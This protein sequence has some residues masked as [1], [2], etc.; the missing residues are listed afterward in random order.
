MCDISFLNRNNKYTFPIISC[1]VCEYTRHCI[2]DNFYLSIFQIKKNGK[3]VKMALFGNGRCF[4]RVFYR[5]DWWNTFKVKIKDTNKMD[6][7]YIYYIKNSATI[8]LASI[9]I[10]VAIIPLRGVGLGIGS[11]FFSSIVGLIG[12]F[13]FTNFIC[14]LYVQEIPPKYILLSILFGLTVSQVTIMILC[15]YIIGIFSDLIINLFGIIGGYVYYKKGGTIKKAIIYI[16]LV[17]C[18]GIVGVFV[19]SNIYNFNTILGIINP[20]TISN[21]TIKNDKG[22]V[23][24]LSQ[25]RGKYLVVDCWYE[26]NDVCFKEFPSFQKLCD[27]YSLNDELK[28]ISVNIPYSKGEKN[29]QRVIQVIIS[30][31]GYRSQR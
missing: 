25:F 30:L 22:K 27:K 23:L 11:T 8:F 5:R 31:K 16:V 14:K 12:Y 20:T 10:T 28:C 18:L 21:F 3:A 4:N 13:I 9:L 17:Y 19:I 2:F 26:R 24:S 6:L 15:K 7:K 29:P 1:L